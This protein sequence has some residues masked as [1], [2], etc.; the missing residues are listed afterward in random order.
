MVANLVRW[1]VTR[2]THY[3]NREARRRRGVSVRARLDGPYHD[4]VVTRNAG[5]RS[6]QNPSG[7]K[8]ASATVV[9]GNDTLVGI[10]SAKNCLRALLDGAYEG[11]PGGSVKDYMTRDVKT[12]PSNLDNMS[13]VRIFMCNFYQRLLAVDDVSLVGQITRCNLL[14]ALEQVVKDKKLGSFHGNSAFFT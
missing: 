9:D 4:K 13:V 14:R 7:K 5:L 10:L 8:I 3:E 1:C 12:T 6:A 11:L 2:Y